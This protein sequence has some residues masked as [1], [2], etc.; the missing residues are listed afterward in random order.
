VAEVALSLVLVIG[1]GLFLKSFTTIMGM[2]LGFRTE[3]VLAM[4]IS[5]PDLRYPTAD[6][7]LAFYEELESRV[8]ALPG[9]QAVAYANR[10]P[11]RGGWSTGIQIENADGGYGSPDSQAVNP[12]YFETLGIPLVRGR[13]LTP[14]DRK[15]QPYAA[16]VNL[17][18]ARRYLNGGDP[19][20]RRF[21]RSPKS[22]WISIVGVVNDVRRAGKTKE[23][24]PQ[25]YLAA[26][27]T[28]VYPV[29]LSDFAVRTQGDPR[30]MLKAIQSQVWAIDAGQPITAVRTM[31]EIVS[32]TVA[33][34]RFQ[35][36]LLGVFAAVA[37]A[38][39]MIGVLSVLSYAVNQR[40]NE[41][42]VRIALGASPG[43][44]LA[45][46]MK[47]AGALIGAG[48]IFGLGGA[49]ALTRLVGHLL[50]QV[51]PHDTATYAAAVTILITVAFLAA[52]IPARRGA[53]ADPLVA[54]R[55]E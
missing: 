22:M 54:L 16:V 44:I 53:R 49:W 23:M 13:L 24:L 21:R 19:I 14:A 32:R 38:L 39:A 18:F 5:L 11:M 6:Q 12:A 37:M 2:D 51:Q 40:M 30:Q 9:V 55:Y 26:A 28:D 20:G 1:A 10:L 41:I 7:R 35:M 27:Q 25:I 47:Q 36:L 52:I 29:R 50:F 17:A 31:D 48:V 15:G 3:R 43:R 33:E 42:G 34:Q 4:S 46:V 8:R 45:L